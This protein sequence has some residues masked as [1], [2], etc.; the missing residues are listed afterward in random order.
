MKIAVASQN[1]V[2]VHQHFGHATQ[3]LI[4]EVSEDGCQLTE[5]RPNTPACGTASPEEDSGHS[6]DYMQHSVDLVSDCQAVVVAR[7]GP[8]AVEKLSYKGVRAVVIPDF[9]DSALQRLKASGLLE[10]PVKSGEKQFSWLKEF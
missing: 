5:I 9:I 8:A 4:Y 6:E 7:I 10:L 1:Q 2:M 3:F